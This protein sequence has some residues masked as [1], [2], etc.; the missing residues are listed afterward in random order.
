[1][2]RLVHWTRPFITAS[3]ECPKCDPSFPG[4]V[5]N[6]D[7]GDAVVCEC[8]GARSKADAL[9]NAQLPAGLKAGVVV[10]L[11]PLP[12]MS[13]KEIASWFRAKLM[14]Q[15]VLDGK[16]RFGL[17]VGP[18]GTGKSVLLA[19]CVLRAVMAG[20]KPVFCD[21]SDPYRALEVA[22]HGTGGEAINIG[23][24]R[25]L[26]ADFV[27]MD[28]LGQQRNANALAAL[29]DILSLRESSALPTILS[30]RLTLPMM[31]ADLGDS[32]TDVL[33][34]NMAALDYTSL[35]GRE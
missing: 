34:A 11:K 17:V 2:R 15:R 1:M 20:K 8:A 26:R 19:H 7:I 13:P 35:R 12:S 31:A 4:Y 27:V 24:D 21:V 3:V 29:R 23:R 22:G 14:V 5:T 10:D 33:G 32:L 25:I 9:T 6:W 28:N 16:A 18:A 30:S